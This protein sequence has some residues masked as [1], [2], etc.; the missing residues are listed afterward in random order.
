MERDF[1]EMKKG[2]ISLDNLSLSYKGKMSREILHR[3]SL[4][5]HAGELLAIVGSSGS[6]KST[7]GQL[8]LGL[9]PS[10]RCIKHGHVRYNGLEL[11]CFDDKQMRKYR[12]KEIGCIFQDPLSSLNPT[13]RVGF[14]ILESL[15]L[16]YS[17]L[18]RAQ[19]KERVVQ[20]FSWL[21]IRNPNFC[22]Y[23]YPHEL[24]GGMRQR[25]AIA[26]A[27]VQ[28]PKVLI[29]DEPTSSLDTII[30]LQILKILKKVQN[31]LHMTI[32]FI[33]HDLRLVSGF[34]DRIAV[35]HQGC[36]VEIGETEPLLRCVQQDY[37]RELL[38]AVEDKPMKISRSSSSHPLV[39]MEN[40]HY[41]FFV[42][43]SR[44]FS[45]KNLSFTIFGGQTLGL[46]GESG[47]GKTTVAFLLA[48][49]LKPSEGK[50]LLHQSL[51]TRKRD[52][53]ILF[54][55]PSASLNP[56][57]TIS[58]ILLEP[59][60]ACRTKKRDRI[61][62]QLHDVLQLVDLDKILLGRYPH[63]LSGGQKQRVAIAR[64]IASGPRILV[65]DEPVTALDVIAQAKI[66][67][68]LKK[69]QTNLGLAYLFI[70]H[71]L[72]IVKHFADYVAV[73]KDGSIVEYA[74][75][76]EIFT[77]PQHS[78]TK[79]MLESIPVLVSARKELQ[80]PFTVHL[81]EDFSLA[82]Q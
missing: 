21:G 11:S 64:A 76:S 47:C 63:E 80:H 65:C 34:A 56:K 82:G 6:G 16:K 51:V 42:K 69:L 61:T 8:L 43:S 10:E 1:K 7:L 26:M 17:S 5:V 13:M 22:F 58:E 37:T 46:I 30:Q 53:Q 41:T 9:I 62:T 74:K 29:A 54:Q 20:L 57:M 4:D 59:L 15:F 55:D 73:M 52:I 40:V 19:G 23:Q 35:M 78:Y 39:R 68:L 12:G 45:V 81:L 33:T 67:D 3:I 75:T 44:K 72:S 70:S 60:Q 24:S 48:Q 14:Q 32:I 2:V 25:I 28:E 77:C 36:I 27:L 66:I 38:L 18:S 71:D 79:R 31:F 50:I 49:L